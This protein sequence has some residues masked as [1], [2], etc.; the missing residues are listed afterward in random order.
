[1]RRAPGI[2]QAIRWSDEN[3]CVPKVSVNGHGGI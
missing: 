1:L 3:A 2:V